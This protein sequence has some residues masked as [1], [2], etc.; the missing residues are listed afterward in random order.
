[1]PT[2]WR[3]VVNIIFRN[4]LRRKI[5]T[6][7]TILGIGVGVTV[8]IALGALADGFQAGYGSM[9]QGSKADLVLSQPDAMDVSYSSVKENVG[10]ELTTMPEVESVSG[11]LQGLV[12]TENEPFFIV[13]GFPEN[14]FMLE[15]FSARE[16]YN[17]F[18]RIPRGLRGKPILLGSA[19]AEVM[20]KKVGD[21]LRI[22]STTYRIVGIYETGDIFEDSGALLRLEDAQTLLGKSD[23]VSL[24]YIRLAD[25]S[26][27]PRLEDRIERKWPDLLLSGTAEFANQQSM[28]SMLRAFVWVIGGLAILIGGVGMLNAQLMA[29]FE[30]TREIGV[31]RATGWKRHQVL[32]MILGESIVVCLAGGLFGLLQGWLLI[33]GLSKIT[34]L[35]GIQTGSIGL[36]LIGQA[37]LVVLLLGLVGGLYPAWRASMLQPVEALRYEGGSARA[38]RLPFGG[39][40]V[41]SL[42]QRSTRSLLTLGAIGLTVG[43]ILA[44]EGVVQGFVA[45]FNNMASGTDAEIMIRQADISDTTLSVIDERV[46]ESIAAMP[47]AHSASGVVFTGLLLPD[48]GVMFLLQGYSPNEI[49]LQRFHLVEGQPLNGNRQIMLGRLMADTLKK[50]IGDLVEISGMRFRVV[51]IYETNIGWEQTG[52]V[53]TLRDAQNFVGRPRQVSMIAVKLNDAAQAPVMVDRINTKYPGVYAALS[54]EF[55]E[56]MPDIQSSNA[57][58]DGISLVAIIA[59]GLSVLNTMLMSVFERTREIGVLRALGW[60]RHAVLALILRESVLLGLLG[61]A[62]GLAISFGL[63]KLMQISAILG[64][65]VDPVWTWD[66]FARAFLLSVLLG[67]TGGLYPAYRATR[68]S[69]VEAL[70]Y[71]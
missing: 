57:M 19:A 66:I 50:G 54:A 42:W 10:M 20:K 45:S 18:E 12:Q 44:L 16:G 70:R 35:M 43:A 61:G 67:A 14:S 31:L 34:V 40:A 46:V 11:M 1:M 51:G 48:S 39:M 17:L 69:P 5:R 38:H 15:R 32:E 29:V 4:L 53:V 36:G 33:I 24:F 59:G 9:M 37:M 64:S 7:L 71:E 2:T 65:W 41:Q 47:E 13:F 8:I 3:D 6:L 26:L 58:L 28:Q 63:I 56:E 21:T 30:R 55:A 22:T 25:T 23:Q 60:H 49:I 62:A 68:L 27:R 52:G